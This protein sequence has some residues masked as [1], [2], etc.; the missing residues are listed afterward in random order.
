MASTEDLVRRS[1]V[2]VLEDEKLG[3]AFSGKRREPFLD[4]LVF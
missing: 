2:R 3:E 1:L 4:E